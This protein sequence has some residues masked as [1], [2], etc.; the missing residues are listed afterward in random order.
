MGDFELFVSYIKFQ[1]T[2]YE[3]ELFEQHVYSPREIKENQKKARETAIG[4]S[5][6]EAWL[7]AVRF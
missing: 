5:N 3:Y 4:Y 1:T 6:G 7:E 2:P